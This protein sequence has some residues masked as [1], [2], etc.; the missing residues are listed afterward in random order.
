MVDLIDLQQNRLHN[1]VSNEL[2]PRILKMMDD[3]LLPPR[4]EVIDHDHIITPG[5][6]FIHKMAPHESRP[7]RHD[8]P[9]PPPRD[10][11]WDAAVSVDELGDDA[12]DLISLRQVG[13]D[14]EGSGKRGA[15]L[16]GAEAGERGLEDEEG[17]ADQ[18]ADQDEKQPL[19]LEE[20]VDGSG[21]RSRVLQGFGGVRG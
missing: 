1:I 4:E 10:R 19:L 9:Q 21:E 2:K 5:D 16:R 14:V 17:G 20:V 6:E 3:V 18:D 11:G 13:G 12:R 8:D 15:G 7:A